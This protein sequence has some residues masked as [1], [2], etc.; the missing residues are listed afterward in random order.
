MGPIS[1]DLYRDFLNCKYKAFLKISGKCGQKSD[2]ESLQAALLWDYRRQAEERLLRSLPSTEISTNP[3]DLLKAI[4]HGY[5]VVTDGHATVDDISVHFN[6]LVLAAP[7]HA[8]YIP[9]LFSVAHKLSQEDRLLAAFCG[10]ALERLQGKPV[11]QGKVIHGEQFTVSSVAIAKLIPTVKK[12]LR[13][14]ADLEGSPPPLRLNSHCSICEFRRDCDAA[15]LEKDDLS[16]LRGLKPKELAKLNSKGIFTVTQ[17]SYTF[18]PRKR[19]K[20]A[21]KV[22]VK[23][24]HALQALAIR[25][26]TVYVASKPS[27]PSTP[28]RLY[29]DVE[30]IPDRDFYY[31]IGVTVCNETKTHH[32]FW[33]NHLT[34]EAAI[35]K[36]FLA[37]AATFTDFTI[38]SYGSYESRWLKMMQQRHGGDKT[39]IQALQSHSC[40]VLSA[41]YGHVYFPTHANDLKSIASYLGFRWSSPDASGLQS[42]AWRQRWEMDKLQATKDELLLYNQEDCLALEC[43]TH[44][45]QR[46]CGNDGAECRSEQRHFNR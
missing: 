18:R 40:N 33:A 32:S 12:T 5:A 8:C 44:T 15:A 4:R 11:D 42:I 41:I 46:I 13:E 22:L 14:L 19:R 45:L 26:N 1:N 20:K 29:L 35:W 23:H 10:L 43:V 25:T 3:P 37:L 21:A 28:T 2:Y 27:L 36:S 16:L 38:Y 30:G 34:D 24:D 31:L 6:A 17:H 7:R 9:V 39:L